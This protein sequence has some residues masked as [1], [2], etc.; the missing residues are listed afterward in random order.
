VTAALRR[1]KDRDKWIKGR[2]VMMDSGEIRLLY[3]KAAGSTAVTIADHNLRSMQVSGASALRS[4]DYVTRLAGAKT[5]MEVIE[6]S[7]AH[8]RN[9]LAAL[10]AY[11]D[12]L[13]DLA[14]K[15]R[16]ICLAHS[17]RSES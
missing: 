13:V 1:P 6:I 5:G 14:R 8:Y 15:M 11:A 10:A 7:G 4:L 17:E 9:Q 16:T 12:N 2:V 3:K